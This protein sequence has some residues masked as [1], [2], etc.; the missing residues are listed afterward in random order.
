[1]VRVQTKLGQLAPSYEGPYTIVRKNQG[2]SYVLRDV[3]GVLTPRNYTSVE[4]KLISTDEVI[5]LDDEGNEIKH[6]EIEAIINHRGDHR[7]REYLV[8]WKNYSSE[9]DEWVSAA[10]INATE[11]LRTYW[12]KLGVPYK[13]KKNAKY[14][15]SPTSSITLKKNP[16]GSISK[17]IDSLD[18]DNVTAGDLPSSDVSSLSPV[19]KFVS[20]RSSKRASATAGTHP[21][22]KRSRV[23][24][25]RSTRRLASKSKD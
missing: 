24:T 12:K 11:T 22:T 4:L 7:N 17:F 21:S 1:M 20:S 23:V 14:T 2:N 8:R 6:F 19:T 5:E 10:N 9:W 25:R 13:P 3:T 18:S 16:P 15:Y